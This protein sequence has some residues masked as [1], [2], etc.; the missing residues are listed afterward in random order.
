MMSQPPRPTARGP[1]PA[2]G[3]EVAE[4]T[5]PTDPGGSLEVL[6]QDLVQLEKRPLR[7]KR[8]A[9]RL[10]DCLVILQSTNVRM[11]VR[12]ALHDDLV[13]FSAFGPR[14]RGTLNGVAVRPDQLLAAT[15]GARVDVIAEP[16]YESVA[17]LVPPAIVRSQ[18]PGWWRRS[19]PAPPETRF[20]GVAE[21]RARDLFEWGKRLAHLAE[22]RPERF[23]TGRAA[24]APAKAALLRLLR[25][26]LDTAHPPR[27]GRGDRTLEGHSRIVKLAEDYAAAHLGD[28]LYVE[29]FCGALGVSERTLEYAFGKVMSM[30][31]VAFL[32][33]LR[34]HRVRQALRAATRGSTTVSIE[35]LNG[36][37][38]HFGEFSRAYKDLFG[39][40]PSETLRRGADGRAMTPHLPGERQ[41]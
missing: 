15:A 5:D 8:L 39:E 17:I 10:E 4:I 11:R 16:G 6:D 24:L 30:T 7:A 2:P 38:S 12:T 26:A 40:L 34:L 35:A 13:V 18:L 20:L 21:P 41:G 1:A 27:F 25:A 36:G 3:V 19:T 31:P 22:Q 14:T 23:A 37:F 28:H 9:V 29:D 33:R 32:R